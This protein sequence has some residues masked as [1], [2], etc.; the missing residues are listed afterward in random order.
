[1]ARGAKN[2]RKKIHEAPEG[3][4]LVSVR[5]PGLPPSVN[6]LWR[7]VG[8]RTYKPR[9]VH[10]WQEAATI[11]IRLSKTAQEAAHTGAACYL[12]V[13][14]TQTGRLM[15]CDNREKA[16]QDCLEMAAV[17]QDDSQITDHRTVRIVTGQPDETVLHVWA[18][19]MLPEGITEIIQAERGLIA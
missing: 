4:A 15:D 1:M 8:N 6:A 7:H 11:C 5:L 2:A 10:E 17:V 9:K 3:A 19:D 18:G 12:L 14:K 13:L 16:L